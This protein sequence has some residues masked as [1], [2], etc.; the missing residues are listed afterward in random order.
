M[1]TGI[2]ASLASIRRRRR[3]GTHSQKKSR[4]APHRHPADNEHEVFVTR[5][6]IEMVAGSKDSA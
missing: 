2:F 5:P 6:H 1:I 3:I 4:A